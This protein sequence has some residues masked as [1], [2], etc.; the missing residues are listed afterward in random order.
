MRRGSLLQ[1]EV[2]DDVDTGIRVFGNDDTA[3]CLPRQPVDFADNDAMRRVLLMQMEKAFSK[4][5]L[6]VKVNMGMLY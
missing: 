3:D 6:V 5:K 1:T 2:F 4:S